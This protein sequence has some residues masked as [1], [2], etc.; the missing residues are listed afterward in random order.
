[1]KA[2]VI[3]EFGNPGV[4]KLTDVRTPQPRPGNVLV[5]ILAA[6]LHRFDHSLREGSVADNGVA[7]N[8]VLLPWVA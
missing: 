8:L 6:G 4:L 7:G 5:K 3:N 1:M 2:A